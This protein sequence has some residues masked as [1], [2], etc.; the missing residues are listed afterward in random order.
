M[1]GCMAQPAEKVKI[2]ERAKGKLITLADIKEGSVKSFD[3]TR[4]TYRSIGKGNPAIVCCNGLGVGTFFWVYLEKMFRNSHQVVT[5]DYRGHGKSELKKDTKSYNLAALV[6]DC[7]A[8]IDDLGLKKA[9]FIGH[10]LGVQVIYEVYR[11]WPERVAAL[12]P[13]F[14]TYGHPM[15]SFYNTRLSRYLFEICYK[16]A[17]TFPKQGN[18]ISYLLLRNPLSFYMGGLLKIMNIGMV[19]KEDI[20]RYIQ[21]ILQ[22]EPVFFS[23]LLKSAQEHT[24]EDMLKTIKVPTMIV[25]GEHDQFTPMWISKKMHRLIPESELFVMNKATHAGLVEQHDLINLRIEKFLN[26]NVRLRK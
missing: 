17:T 7:R 20:D 1:A 15:D 2:S 8:V 4:I 25:A 21:H 11:H 13:C 24:A 16:V 22:V 6:K 12:I 18:W 14:G 26:E 5:W 9:V 23:M 10:S 19:K 3:G